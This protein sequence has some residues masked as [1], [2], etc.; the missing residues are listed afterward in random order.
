MRINRL[1]PITALIIGSIALIIIIVIGLS[2]TITT[3]KNSNKPIE[4]IPKSSAVTC[5]NKYC[6]FEEIK[7]G[8]DWD[9][10]FEEGCDCIQEYLK[11][12]TRIHLQSE[13]V[14][15]KNLSN[16]LQLIASGK[17]QLKLD[18]L[19]PDILQDKI[20]YALKNG[21]L[22]QDMNRRKLTVTTV[23]ETIATHYVEKT[24]L[25]KDP[26]IGTIKAV[27]R[28]PK[29]PGK[30]PG[31]IGLPGHKSSSSSYLEHNFGN[32]YPQR[33][34]VIIVPTLRGSCGGKTE[35][36]TALSLLTKGLTFQGIR[37]YETLLMLRYLKF[38]NEVDDKNIGIIC[39]SG[40]CAVLNH[41]IRTNYKSY[42][43][44]VTDL[45]AN[46]GEIF[47][48]KDLIDS[49]TPDLYPLHFLITDFSTSEVPVLKIKYSHIGEME[50]VFS[51]F[52]KYL[53]HSQV[54]KTNH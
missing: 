17:Q 49:T 26:I 27:I 29:T 32:E 13:T 3:I 46:Y 2:S 42:R 52:N 12:P 44:A 22:L 30:Y 31:I 45:T 25:L 53:K 6:I 1:K 40:G 21:F 23:K 16:R 50:N 38:L 10:L 14:F 8:G 18:P 35:S 54:Q 9:C 19:P 39:H 41:H 51:F 43:A 20:I 7:L 36:K 5:P 37:D 11:I 47:N 28:K 24:L 48:E 4:N 34:Y 33:G 15:E